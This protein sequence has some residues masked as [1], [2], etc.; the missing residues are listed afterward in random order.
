MGAYRD[1]YRSLKN[2]DKIP[3]LY[4]D[5][6]PS[7]TR[8]GL[9][10][11]ASGEMPD[12]TAFSGIRQ[13]K[14]ILLKLNPEIAHNLLEQLITYSTGA[15]VGFADQALVDEMIVELSPSKYGLRSMI[16]AIVQ[17]PLFLEK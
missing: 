2:G 8:L 17:S 5:G 13:F 4:F 7:K 9:P 3:D 10:V 1:R 12:G 11:D 16:H 14:G 6:R 15:P